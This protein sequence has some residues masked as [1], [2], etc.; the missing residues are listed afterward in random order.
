MTQALY[1]HMNNKTMKKINKNA[2]KKPHP[3]QKAH[4]IIIKIPVLPKLIST[5]HKIP[6]EVSI[7]LFI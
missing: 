6:I 7:V 4:P 3:M 5:L 2:L 1:A